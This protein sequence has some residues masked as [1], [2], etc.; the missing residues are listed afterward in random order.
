M[1]AVTLEQL[2]AL[3]REI[4]ALASAGIPLGKGLVRVAEELSGPSSQLADRL[5]KRID[6]GMSL[7]EAVDA[8]GDSLPRSYRVLVRA[9]H[10]SGRLASALEGYANTIDRLASLRR[11]VGLALIYPIFVLM[12]IWVLYL[13]ANERLL[14]SYDWLEFNDKFWVEPLRLHGFEFTPTTFWTL[15]V[16]LPLVCLLVVWLLWRRSSL[17][18]EVGMPG[19]GNWLNWIPG[20]ARV[21]RLGQQACVS[22]LLSLFIQQR[23]PLVE[24]LPLA[25]ESSGNVEESDQLREAV[26]RLEAGQP[27]GS[28]METLR[29]LPPLVRLALVSSREV[30]ELEQGLQ[31]AAIKYHERAQQL[32]Q[33]L[34]LY[35]PTIITLTIGGVATAVYAL[36]LFQPYLATLNEMTY[37]Q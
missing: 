26:N 11:V 32:S 30:E 1:Q 17:A 22:D 6:S 2:V 19:L 5:A 27:I 36:L 37:W 8:E 35:L 29:S 23:V 15:V 13:F 14:P 34:S 21:R 12:M 28:V 25:M 3:N 9:G 10:R 33:G 16:G 4:S 24:S 18:T 7:P 31:Q 20:V